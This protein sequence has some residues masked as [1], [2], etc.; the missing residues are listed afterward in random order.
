MRKKE[1]KVTL[2]VCSFWCQVDLII[3]DLHLFKSNYNSP[4]DK[5]GSNT[6][7]ACLL[8]EVTG[9]YLRENKSG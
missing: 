6:V 8:N 3:A 7:V 5:R 9:V 4:E 2:N 1:I